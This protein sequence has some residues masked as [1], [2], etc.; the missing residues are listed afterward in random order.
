ML[1]VCDLKVLRRGQ[2]VL[3]GLTFDVHTGEIVALLG[4]NGAGRS[5]TAM[6]LMGLLPRQG[7]IRWQGLA[8]EHLPPHEVARSGLGFVPESRD[9]FPA[10]NV[11]QNLLLGE[12]AARST[13]AVDWSLEE[14]LSLFPSLAARL[15]T[16]ADKLSGGEQQMLSLCRTLLGQ[17]RMLI[18]DEPAEGLSPQVVAQLGYV[19]ELARQR[20]LAILL[21]EQKLQL[22][23]ALA[24]RALVLGAGRIVADLAPHEV[25]HSEVCK[26]W[27]MV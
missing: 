9:V 4:R 22:T 2:P 14:L 20:G 19:L 12:P 10:L 3:N 24:D 25:M 5:T 11:A 27:L 23:H 8:L 13:R 21:I 26:Q 16:Q 18:V 6:A 17:P 1:E 15:N 7:C